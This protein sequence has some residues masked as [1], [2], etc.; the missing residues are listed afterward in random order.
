MPPLRR[1]RAQ[2][3]RQVRLAKDVAGA[4]QAAS[5]K[6]HRARGGPQIEEAAAALDRPAARFIDGEAVGQ[7][8]RRLH[9][10]AERFRAV[11]A[12]RHQRGFDHAGH[13]RGHE[14]RHGDH[15]LEAVRFGTVGD[16][17]GEQ[18]AVAEEVRRGELRHGAYTRERVHFAVARAHEDGRFAAESEVGE[19]RDG[20]GEHGR[21]TRVHRVAALVVNAHGGAGGEA[22]PRR[23]R[24][25]QPARRVARRPFL[26]AQ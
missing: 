14:P 22:A 20:G 24:S 8:D 6:E 12:E 25:A 11:L 3:T 4:R 9:H 19:L 16:F 18:A 1:H 5:G 2:R 21:H 26:G 13:E 23:Y 17:P 10:F 7:F 15:P